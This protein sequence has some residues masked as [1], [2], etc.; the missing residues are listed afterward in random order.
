MVEYIKDSVVPRLLRS[1]EPYDDE[2][3]E[4]ALINVYLGTET[5]ELSSKISV[6]LKENQVEPN[7]ELVAYIFEAMLEKKTV[8]EHGV[9]FTPY[10]IAE[11]IISGILEGKECWNDEKII[12]PSCGCGNFLI[13]AIKLINLK[14]GVSIKSIIEDY[15]YGIDI[16]E[17]NVRR[18]KKLIM[19]YAKR[20]NVDVSEEKINICCADSLKT[21]WSVCFHTNG[22]EYIV[23][24]PPYVNTHDM[25]KDT[26][27]FLKENFATT[28]N[29]VFNIFYAFIEHAV[30]FLN[31]DGKLSYIVPNN[32]LTIKSATELREFLAQ[33]RLINKILD[34][35]DNMIFKPVRTY[36]CIITVDRTK[37]DAVKFCVLDKCSDIEQELLNIE[38]EE[39]QSSLLDKNGWKL[40][41]HET[42][43]NLRKIENQFR[44]IKEF[45]RT[46]IATLRDDVFMVN[47]EA[48]EF[49]KIV[50]GHKY[51]IE[52]SIVKTLYK[53]PELK[54]AANLADVSRYIIFPYVKQGNTFQIIPEEQLKALYPNTYEYLVVMQDELNKRDNGKGNSVAWYAYGR[55]QGLNRYGKKILF[56]TFADVP[57]FMMVADDN[58]LFCNGYGVFENDFLELDELLPI[59]NSKIMHYYVS[60]TS[61]SIEGGY[62]CYQ[63]KYIE[64]FSIPWFDDD[65]KKLLRTGNKDEIEALLVQKYKIAI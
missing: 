65:E 8:S 3:I 27:A 9:V 14:Y 2:E 37:S 53:I 41:D 26:V 63:K 5:D 29:G 23:G 58:A 46:G 50:D 24:N 49:Y 51:I 16:D 31:A 52:K 6:L 17:N 42:F 34:F 40:V 25:S 1:V 39:I 18:C 44:P 22:F 21:D 59:L 30:S 48:G 56:P 47:E 10:Y 38:Y 33:Q 11:Y 12:D 19:A 57:K 62:Y 15:L 28:K 35:G 64:K 55:T 13:A 61:Y 4:D 7:T 54:G 43:I 60:N 32:F 20:N 36:N 45:V